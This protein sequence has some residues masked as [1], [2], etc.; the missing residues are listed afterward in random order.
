MHDEPV[1]RRRVRPDGSAR[2]LSA[3]T[4]ADNADYAWSVSFVDGTVSYGVKDAVSNSVRGVRGG[5]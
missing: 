4:L 3:T 2:L 1:H 5:F